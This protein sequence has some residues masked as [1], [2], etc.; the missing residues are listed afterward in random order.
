MDI[1]L[2]TAINGPCTILTM[3][4]YENLEE[5]DRGVYFSRLTWLPEKNKFLE[6]D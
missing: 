2:A 1:I 6:W 5:I 3:K 4:E